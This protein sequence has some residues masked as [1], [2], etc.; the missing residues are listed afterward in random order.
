[1]ASD[2]ENYKNLTLDD[3]ET[4]LSILEHYVKLSRRVEH[5][6]RQVQHSNRYQSANMFDVNSIIQA[7]LQQ[8][9][10]PEEDEEIG[11]LTPEEISKIK[12]IVNK[13]KEKER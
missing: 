8:Q 7:V 12:D 5:I 9:K 2:T 3:I 11:E 4:A 1:M 6:L 10:K 13:V